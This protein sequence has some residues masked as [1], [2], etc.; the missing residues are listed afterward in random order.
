MRV[1][2]VSASTLS[3]MDAVDVVS[4]GQGKSFTINV[5]DLTH[6]SVTVGESNVNGNFVLGLLL[7]PEAFVGLLKIE[8][9]FA[10]HD[11]VEARRRF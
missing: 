2:T 1:A 4:V 5:E 10:E 8:I 9:D 6:G 7:Q 11:E 3:K